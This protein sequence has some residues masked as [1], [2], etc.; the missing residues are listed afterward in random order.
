MTHT[1]AATPTASPRGRQRRVKCSRTS[2]LFLCYCAIIG[3]VLFMGNGIMLPGCQASTSYRHGHTPSPGNIVT[4]DSKVAQKQYIV[5]LS[6]AAKTLQEYFAQANL[7]I[8]LFAN[9]L[10]LGCPIKVRVFHQDESC[11]SCPHP[12]LSYEGRREQKGCSNFILIGHYGTLLSLTI[13]EASSISPL[14]AFKQ[15]GFDDVMGAVH[16]GGNTYG[17]SHTYSSSGRFGSYL[18]SASGTSSQQVLVLILLTRNTYSISPEG[19]NTLSWHHNIFP[20]EITLDILPVE[21]F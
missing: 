19:K 9:K 6:T 12:P 16:R 18:G 8:K 14:R 10:I 11:L 15:L 3:F 20:I 4:T 17:S 2:R 7:E 21:D 13:A 1:M 5:C